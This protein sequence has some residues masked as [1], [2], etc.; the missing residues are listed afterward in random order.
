MSHNNVENS[1]DKGCP[2]RI[3]ILGSGFAGIEVLKRVQRKFRRNNNIDITLVSRDNFVLFTPMLPEVAAGMVETRHIV[4]PVRTFCKKANFY[5]AS[6]DSIDLKN[7]EIVISHPIGNQLRPIYWDRHTL[8]YDYL[9]VALGSESNFFGMPDV[10]EHALT[11]KTLD[12]A[13][14]LRN[15][16]LN[17]LEQ[18]SLEHDNKDLRKSLLTFVVVGGGFS[19]V[20]TVGSLNDFVKGTVK[21]YYKD[22]YMT[23]VKIILVSAQDKILPEVGEEL[24]DYALQKLKDNGVEFIM[25]SQVKGAT[26]NTAKLDNGTVIPTYTLIWTA[27]VTPSDR[28]MIEN[29]PCQHGKGGSIITNQYLEVPGYTNVY[30]VGDCASIPNPYTGKD[31]PPT[32]Q[33][34]IEEGRLAAKNISYEIKGKKNKKKTFN[35]KNKGVMAQIGKRTGVAQLFGRKFHGLIAWWLWRTFYLSNLPTINKKLKVMGDWTTD[36]LFQPDVSMIKR[37]VVKENYHHDDL[38]SHN[39]KKELEK[40]TSPTCENK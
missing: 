12:D 28:E 19:G 13:I 39:M 20:E 40:T 2:I 23:D 18:A 1:N 14:I 4:T 8:K 7:K 36:L 33:N 16:V 3:L 24:G 34:A 29:L 32:A 31:Y 10:Q 17:I 6:V 25:N 15:H 21:E 22:I 11:M 5:E 37:F 26:P 9:V 30:A 35:Y 27:G 38:G